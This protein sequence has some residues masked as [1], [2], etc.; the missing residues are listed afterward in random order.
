[1]KYKLLIA[2]VVFAASIYLLFSFFFSD[3]Q[4]NKYSSIAAVKEQGAIDRGWVPSIL[5]K[6]AYE[7]TETHDLDKN[8]LF[9]SFKYKD[10]D[11][12]AFLQQLSPINDEKRTMY[13][14]DFLFRIDKEK[15]LVKY[16]N[17]TLTHQ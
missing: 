11:E 14:E 6:S 3:V 8:E 4:I 10:T 9:G 1:M 7:I 13:W 5:P 15:N 12:K 17:R 2:A 16:R